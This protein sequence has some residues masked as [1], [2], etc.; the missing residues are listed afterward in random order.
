[1]RYKLTYLALALIAFT[2]CNRS[3]IVSPVKENTG[4]M[5]FS[6]SSSDM[7]TKALV[8]KNDLT[9]YDGFKLKVYDLLYN[10]DGTLKK[11]ESK[12]SDF[13][14]W[15][16]TEIIYDSSDDEEDMNHWPY[17]DDAVYFWTES[18]VH[19]F[20]GWTSYDAIN[21][22]KI[23]ELFGSDLAVEYPGSVVTANLDATSHDLNVPTVTFTTDTKQ[24]DMMYSDVVSRSMNDAANRT[25]NRKDVHINLNH[26]FT[27]VSMSVTNAMND[28]VV[29]I[30]S[31]SMPDLRNTG[32]ATIT[33][34]GSTLLSYS[35]VTLG[36]T[37]FMSERTNIVL[38][39][40]NRSCDILA[41]GGPKMYSSYNINNCEPKFNWPVKGEYLA[42]TNLKDETNK[43][44]ESTDS[45]IVIN[46]TVTVGDDSF[47]Y[48]RRVK[49]DVDEKGWE[50][51][52]HYHYNLKF[53][54]KQIF[55]TSEV[56][57]WTY[58]EYNLS[59]ADESVSAG[60]LS[61]KAPYNESSTG[62][63]TDTN[64]NEYTYKYITIQDGKAATGTFWIQAPFNGTYIITMEGDTEFF[65]IS[66]ETG[67]INPT[68]NSGNVEFTVTPN[69][70]L[71]RDSD[72][73]I[74]LHFKVEMP[75]G[76][77]VSA[78]SEI[79]RNNYRIILKK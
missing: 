55:L 66:G 16:D 34:G 31:I 30:N 36:D 12:W 38:D 37:P 65:T 54:D 60:P 77:V 50:A 41:S 78:D 62:T 6:V 19:R 72:K 64:G 7:E 79:N 42:P 14:A 49:L 5:K 61:F 28:G 58:G 1:M 33:F 3:E 25:E 40:D 24:F 57:P 26:L 51:G 11:D 15:F 76:E 10:T 4:V 22:T 13:D 68:I 53:I 21:R 44:Y 17:V 52:K 23:S 56:L 18:G 67:Q 73:Y 32:R 69:L 39:S 43:I 45:L 8:G 2:G 59:Y 75:S 35:D 74:T 27:A 47:N 70:D 48:E 9:T 46:Y 63:D 29:T 20:F 71:T